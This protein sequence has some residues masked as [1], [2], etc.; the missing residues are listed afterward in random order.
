MNGNFN[1]KTLFGELL[2]ACGLMSAS[3]AASPLKTVPWNGYSGAASFTFDDG[4]FQ[5]E[6]L[7]Q[8]LGEMPE[9]KV[10]FFLS[11]MSADIL[12]LY[13][14]E[15]ANFA[16]LGH[17]IGN[18]SNTHVHLSNLSEDSLRKEVIDFAGEIQQ[19][20][21]Y[22]G[23]DVNITAHALPYSANSETASKVINERHFI[24]RSSWGSGRH[25]W[26]EEP[27]WT[28]MDSR[29][30]YSWPNAENDLL[31]ALDTAAYIGDFTSSNPWYNP[32]KAP[33][34]VILLNH[35]VSYMG[36]NHITPDAMKKAFKHAVDNNMWVAPFS[37][38]GAY[39]RAHFTLDAA[40]AEA[41]GNK[42]TIK[43]NLPHPNMPKSIP[44]KVTL[45]NDFINSTFGKDANVVLEQK[46]KIIYPHNGVFTIEFT[47]LEVNIC[48]ATAGYA[49]NKPENIPA[50]TSIE[51]VMGIDNIEQ[52][53]NSGSILE[54]KQVTYTLHDVQGK[55]LKRIQSFE[56]PENMPKGVY[57][58]R[59]NAP[60]FT[61]LT[62]KVVH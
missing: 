42:Y 24:N 45:D 5:I 34:W 19:V 59:A 23:A 28:D 29:A 56:V 61:P 26:D 20:M 46:G 1:I 8:I 14:A 31:K 53:N 37:T 52:T 3:F 48:V 6:T 54:N 50:Y 33:A 43:W 27:R 49:Q 57:F 38:V 2:I 44:M 32:V 30:W 18:H 11:N 22:Y 25:N 58:L 4:V 62:R 41:N 13:G 35:G 15:F 16:K 39:Y 17:E 47:D 7:P 9:V 12:N 55:L 36:G 51:T 60:G 10:T 21:G 40:K